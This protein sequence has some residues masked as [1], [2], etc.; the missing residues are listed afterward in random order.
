M[1]TDLESSVTPAVVIVMGVSGAGKTTVGRRLAARLGWAFVDADDHHD[2]AAIEKMSRGEGL[3]DTDRAPWLDRLA[4]LV[5]DRVRH[6]PPTVLACSA[7]KAT[8]RERLQGGSPAVAVVWLDVPADALRQRLTE[9]EGHSVGP[10][11]LPSQLAVLEPPADA[12]H[13]DGTRPPE[14]IEDEVVRRLGL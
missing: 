13:V 1:P 11:L 5:A 6:G 7:L 9:R 10:D 8:Y 4:A 3:S 14:V 2:A 12:L